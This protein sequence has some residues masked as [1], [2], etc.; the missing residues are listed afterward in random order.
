MMLAHV[1]Q[2]E[3]DK[4]FVNFLNVQAVVVQAGDSVV[5]DISAPDGV[6]ASQPATATLSLFVG[7][8][9]ADTAISAYGLAQAYG[10]RALGALLTNDTSVA[11]AAGDILIPVN[12]QDRVARSGAG[13]GKSGFL[14]AGEAYATNTTPV[15]ALKKVFVRAL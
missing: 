9:D 10:Y 15:A 14:F 8:V 2:T 5:W 11:V 13:D 12:A 7:V 1:V 6:R 3:A 4:V